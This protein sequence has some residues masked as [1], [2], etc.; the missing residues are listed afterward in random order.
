V[1]KVLECYV[2]RDVRDQTRVMKAMMNDDDQEKEI[3]E[4]K[5][6]CGNHRTI[7]LSY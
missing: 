6:K 2:N 5:R 1:K 4:E 7:T 3:Q